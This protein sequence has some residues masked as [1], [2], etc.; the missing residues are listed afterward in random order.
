MPS[1]CSGPR[2]NC[3]AT[4][5]CNSPGTQCFLKN[6]YWATCKN[7]CQAGTIDSSELLKF[8]TPWSCEKLG[9][10]TPAKPARKE[11]S[12]EETE[13]D[14]QVKAF[15]FMAV[16][17]ATMSMASFVFV[18]VCLIILGVLVMPHL[19]KSKYETVGSKN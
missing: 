15:S 13:E 8:Q 1:N 19:R 16:M 14:E 10:R 4:H 9:P 2:E 3:I 11:E 6:E 18:V 5:C 7:V 12:K 17:Q